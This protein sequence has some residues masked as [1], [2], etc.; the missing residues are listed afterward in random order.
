MS[1][2]AA[3]SISMSFRIGFAVSP[4]VLSALADRVG[5]RRIF[6]WSATATALTTA[7]IPLFARSYPSGLVPVCAHRSIAITRIGPS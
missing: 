2:T 6:V 4:V 7:L 3:G 1:A 5:A